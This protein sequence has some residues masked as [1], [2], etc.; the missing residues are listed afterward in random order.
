V[1]I[2]TKLVDV[3]KKTFKV[4]FPIVADPKEDISKQLGNV[5]TPSIIIADSKGMVLFIH[6]GVIDDMDLILDVVR[7]FVSQ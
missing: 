2:D 5:A 3:D 1:G 6:E 4:K 7:T